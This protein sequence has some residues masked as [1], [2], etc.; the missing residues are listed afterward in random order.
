[1]WEISDDIP[2]A[3]SMSA[4]LSLYVLQDGFERRQI[5]VDTSDD[6]VS[7]ALSCSQQTHKVI[8]TDPDLTDDGSERA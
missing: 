2:K 8:N 6:S 1:M 4:I 7:H 5:G 3:G